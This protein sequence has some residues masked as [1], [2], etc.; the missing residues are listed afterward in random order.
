MKIFIITFEL[1]N[2]GYNHFKILQKIRAHSFW[3]RLTNYSYLVVTD[4]SPKQIRDNFTGAVMDGDRI[5]VSACPLPAAWS[6]L[7]QDVAKWI[8]ENQPKYS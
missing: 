3:A 8:A 6:G 7:P 2:P 4:L 1:A 5:F